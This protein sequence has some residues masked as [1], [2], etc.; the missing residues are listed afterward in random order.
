MFKPILNYSKQKSKKKIMIYIWRNSV[1][2]LTH[3]VHVFSTA[4]RWLWLSGGICVVL[5]CWRA[6][7]EHRWI[8]TD[9]NR[10]ARVCSVKRTELMPASAYRPAHNSAMPKT[11]LNMQTQTHTNTLWL[12]LTE[13]YINFHVAD[14]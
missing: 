11:L 4:V 7:A 9:R 5:C 13:F 2:I 1:M 14:R 6:A 10:L 8:S 3:I 12:T